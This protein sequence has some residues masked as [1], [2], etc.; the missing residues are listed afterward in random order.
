MSRAEAEVQD[1]VANPWSEPLDTLDVHRFDIE[2]QTVV[3]DHVL[4]P[5]NRGHRPGIDFFFF[6]VHVDVEHTS[7]GFEGQHAGFPNRLA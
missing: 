5:L 4:K 3:G 6:H 7:R 1:H 2:G